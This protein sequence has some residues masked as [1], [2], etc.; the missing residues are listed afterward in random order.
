MKRDKV[1][2][3]GRRH[4]FLKLISGLL[5]IS[6]GYSALAAPAY[7]N[8]PPTARFTITPSNTAIAAGT[9]GTQTITVTD[10]GPSNATNVVITYTPPTTPGITVN[11]VTGAAGACTLTAGSWVCPAVTS[12]ALNASTT[13]TVNMTVADSVAPGTSVGSNTAV[14]SNEFNPGNGAGESLFNIWGAYG[15]SA[16]AGDAFWFGF[17]GYYETYNHNWQYY[18]NSSMLLLPVF[19]YT[20]PGQ[21]EEGGPISAIWPTSQAN[22]P[23]GY[24]L[25]NDTTTSFLYTRPITSGGDSSNPPGSAWWQYNVPYGDPNYYGYSGYANGVQGFQYPYGTTSTKTT[26]NRPTYSQIWNTPITMSLP[27]DPAVYWIARDNRRAWEI[28]TGVYLNQPSPIYICISKVDDGMYAAIDGT[29]VIEQTSW[30]GG[31]TNNSGLD[32]NTNGNYSAGYHEIVYRIVNRNNQF[33]SFE[34]GPGGFDYIGIGT[35]STSDCTQAN[36]TTLTRIAPSSNAVISAAADLAV[37]KTDNVNTVT[38]GGQTTYTVRVTNN[39]PNSVTGATLTDTA[40]TGLSITGYTCSAAA[41]NT[42]TTAPSGSPITLPTLASGAFYEVNVTANVTGRDSSGNVVNTA[43]VDPP[44]GVTDTNTTNNTATDTDTVI[45]NPPVLTISKQVGK[46]SYTTGDNVV[47]TITV[48]NSAANT[49]TSG[50]IQLR[51][52]LPTGMSLV[53]VAQSGGVAGAVSNTSAAG[54]TGEV[55]WTFTPSAGM[56]A[57]QTATFTVTASTNSSTPLGNLT[58]Y[59]SVGGGGDTAAPTPGTACTPTDQCANVTTT[60]VGPKPELTISKS[61]SGTF[62]LGGTGTYT[63]T[64]GNTGTGPNTGAITVLDTLPA[65]MTFNS[66][67]SGSGTVTGGTVNSSGTQTFSF[68]PSTPIQPGQTRTIQVT[69]NVGAAGSLTNYASVGGGGDTAAPT[70][71]TSCTPTDQ[72]ASDAVT[73]NV[74]VTLNK[75]WAAGSTAGNTAALSINGGTAVTSTAP[76]SLATPVA[77]TVAPGGNVSIAETMSGGTYNSSWICQQVSDNSV[78]ASGTGTSGSFTLPTNLSSNVS[79]SFINTPVT[80]T[81]LPAFTCPS[82][83]TAYTLSTTAGN[84]NLQQPL[85][86]TAG[87]TSKTF[88]FGNSGLALTLNYVTNTTMSSG[89]PAIGTVSSDGTALVVS[90]SGNTQSA[91]NKLGTM[92]VSSNIPLLKMRVGLEDVDDQGAFWYIDRITPSG[93]YSIYNRSSATTVNSNGITGASNCTTT[94]NLCNAVVDWN[95]GGSTY[96]LDYYTT[97]LDSNGDVGF[98]DIQVC[99]ANPTVQV[100]KSYPHARAAN[101]DQVALSVTPSSGTANTAVSGTT[102]GAG[103]AV[104]SAPVVMNIKPETTGTAF[105]PFSI[106]EAAA[107]SSNLSYYTSSYSCTNNGTSSST[108]ANGTTTS[109]SYTPKLG[110]NF[111]CTFSNDRLAQQFSLAKT[112]AAGTKDNTQITATTTGGTNNATISSTGT[113]P[114]TDTG[115]AVTVYAG[116]K[117]TLPLETVTAGSAG[118]TYDTTIACTGGTTLASQPMTAA[119]NITIAPSN[120]AT[121]CTYTNTPKASSPIIKLTKYVRNASNSGEKYNTVTGTGY[122]GN[123]LEYCIAYSN[124]GGPASNFKITDLFPKN[125]AFV[126]GSLTYTSPAPDF[127]TLSATPA[128]TPFP[129][130]GTYDSGTYTDANNNTGAGVQFYYGTGQVPAGTTANPTTGAI[131]FQTKIN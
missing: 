16:K 19:N 95:T 31:V 38:L 115:T 94:S 80:S 109:F 125:T 93:S 120:T 8:Q 124:T 44:S 69:V 49:F 47:Y 71:G 98:D 64:I 46:T 55:D 6:G 90:Y 33:K 3:S 60:M 104:T 24:N 50:P 85:T 51:D 17:K 78:V 65:G 106:A 83:S 76:N 86:W 26:D 68:T 10:V 21:S 67:S 20:T 13:I 48:T 129:T 37:T 4:N 56:T 92:N 99:A 45:S 11:S 97:Q 126:L 118:A 114:H 70:P 62:Q 100:Q 22:P 61:H 42:C 82:G 29:Q 117:V 53:S 121:T 72:C 34:S 43:K 103:N 88:T 81:T 128:A 58:N 122:P 113:T 108:I 12:L 116:D 75:T 18:S 2:K 119:Q 40:G 79:C 7:V 25:I 112:W 23:G 41:G 110:D 111:T 15:T 89:S 96:S 66:V 105:V 74:Q 32:P 52:V 36:Y 63:L 123:T 101:T 54:T 39:G 35:K 9:T 131:C 77:A 59:A 30:N 73:S 87:A 130:G 1:S 102:T 5:A 27:E 28:R 127:T 91:G 14:N 84:N 107:G 57:N